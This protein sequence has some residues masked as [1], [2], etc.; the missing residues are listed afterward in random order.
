M[1]MLL[2]YKICILVLG[3][4][5]LISFSLLGEKLITLMMRDCSSQKKL[6][7]KKSNTKFFVRKIVPH[8]I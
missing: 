8:H 7:M 1:H 5:L 3:H 4:K 2:N 6:H